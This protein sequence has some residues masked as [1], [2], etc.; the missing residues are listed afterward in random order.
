MVRVMLDKEEVV[1]LSEIE[2]FE[3]DWS[4]LN[5]YHKNTE[6]S[7]LNFLLSGNDG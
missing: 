4:F 1:P 7:P 3:N 2:D 6:K 5:D